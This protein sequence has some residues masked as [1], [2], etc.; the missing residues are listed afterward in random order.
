MDQQIGNNNYQTRGGV[1]HLTSMPTL[2]NCPT[3]SSLLSKD[4]GHEAQ[5]C[6]NDYMET[7]PRNDFITRKRSFYVLATML[8]FG[9]IVSIKAHIYSINLN[10]KLYFISKYHSRLLF[11]SIVFQE[12]SCRSLVTKFISALPKLGLAEHKPSANRSNLRLRSIGIKWFM[13][14]RWSASRKNWEVLFMRLTFSFFFD[15][16][17]FIIQIAVI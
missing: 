12:H 5:H 15:S 14:F 4:Y 10:V 16:N 3:F 17:Y 13:S 9:I 7:C 2:P 1:P 6:N 11:Y 8:V